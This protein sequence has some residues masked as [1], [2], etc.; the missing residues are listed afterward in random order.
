MCGVPVLT[1]R[2][3]KDQLSFRQTVCSEE[4]QIPI[5]SFASKEGCVLFL[6][7]QKGGWLLKGNPKEISTRHFVGPP[8]STQMDPNGPKGKARNQVG[9]KAL[10]T[11]LFSESKQLYIVSAQIGFSLPPPSCKGRARI[12]G[13]GPLFTSSCGRFTSA[14]TFSLCLLCF[15]GS[16]VVLPFLDC[17]FFCLFVCLLGWLFVCLFV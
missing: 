11:A 6:G 12:L 8:F 15:A 14:Q 9:S 5:H 2:K 17:C 7:T 16:L 10:G 1:F 4:T 13:P 3:P